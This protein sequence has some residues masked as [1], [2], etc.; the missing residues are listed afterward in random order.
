MAQAERNVQLG[1]QVAGRL[2]ADGRVSLRLEDREAAGL[3][4]ARVEVE[5]FAL[6]HA[7]RRYRT[8]LLPDSTGHYAGRLPGGT[9]G[10]HQ[11]Q[12]TVERGADRFTAVL[13]GVPGDALVAPPWN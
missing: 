7:A 2:G 4:S 11:I 13:R 3:D 12:V 8:V 5:G 6:A 1:W 10:L 9:A